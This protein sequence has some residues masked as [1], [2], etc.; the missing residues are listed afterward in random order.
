[1]LTASL[2]EAE[3]Q[4]RFKS[5]LGTFTTTGDLERLRM[6]ILDG[7]RTIWHAKEWR[8]RNSTATLTT[9]VA[10][11]KGPFAPPA[12][13]YKLAHTLGVYRFG[14]D[15][16]QILAPV[17]DTSTA[18]YFLWIDVQTGQLFFVTAPGNASLTLNYQAEFDNN[19]ANVATTIALFPSS[20]MDPL[21]H[22]TKANLFDDL[23]QFAGQVDS[24]RAKGKEAL[25][26]VWQ[27]YNQG[28]ARPRQMAP[29]GLH[30]V[31]LDGYAGPFPILGPG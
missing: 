4:Q 8:F 24:I 27:D 31:R 22:F 30:G 6:A 3:F 5:A 19:V 15:D 25:E 18:A 10:G 9:T 2:V 28:Q 16:A 20:C 12:G 11:G 29:R 7:L 21:Y 14:F 23:P 1:M 17:K 13:L 26:T